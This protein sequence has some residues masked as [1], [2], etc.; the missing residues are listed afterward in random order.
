MG[1]D[2][3]VPLRSIDPVADCILL[4]EHEARDR[5]DEHAIGEDHAGCDGWIK[6]CLPPAGVKRLLVAWAYGCQLI[7]RGVALEL[8]ERRE[9]DL[10]D[11]PQVY[12]GRGRLGRVVGHAAI[13][14][15][16]PRNKPRNT[17][18]A[19][20]KRQTDRVWASRR[21]EPGL[22]QAECPLKCPLQGVTSG[23][24]TVRVATVGDARW[25]T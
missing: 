14:A 24:V 8:E 12:F 13:V 6:E 7:R 22:R 15:R 9:I 19:R 11:R 5:P 23:S 1:G 3:P 20:I 2:A 16:F 10:L 4:I 17:L 25:L 21:F 18:A